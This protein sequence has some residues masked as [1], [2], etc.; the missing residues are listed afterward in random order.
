M[1][2][3]DQ[4]LLHDIN[5]KMVMIDMRLNKLR[6]NYITYYFTIREIIKIMKNGIHVDHEVAPESKDF[7]VIVTSNDISNA[8][9]SGQNIKE[10][11]DTLKWI[12]NII[13]CHIEKG[14]GYHVTTEHNIINFVNAIHQN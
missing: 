11:S 5:S 1:D 13:L 14:Y 2:E 3:H 4:Q 8:T 10:Y 6:K 9:Y 7:T 12:Q